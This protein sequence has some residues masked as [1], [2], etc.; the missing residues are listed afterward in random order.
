MKS[1]LSLVSNVT[2]R[3]NSVGLCALLIREPLCRL[4]MNNSIPAANGG[5]PR[6]GREVVNWAEGGRAGPRGAECGLAPLGVEDRES[7]TD[8]MADVTVPHSG[9]SKLVK[10]VG[11]LYHHA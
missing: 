2:L 3:Q 7:E 1:T 8:R 11:G 5:I 4:I 6:L 9:A 10:S